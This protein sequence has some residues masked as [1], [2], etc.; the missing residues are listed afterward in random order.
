MSRSGVRRRGGRAAAGVLAVM[1]TVAL[2]ACGG[3]GGDPTEGADQQRN[4]D[5]EKISLTISANA[6]SGGKNAVEADWIEN[7]VIPTFIEQ[8]KEKGVEVDV[9]FEPSGVD[10]EDYKTRLALDL[11][12]GDGADIVNIDGIW[13]GE[14]AET[15]DTWRHWTTSWARPR[16]WDGWEQI[17]EAV[18]ANAM[19]RRR[20]L[21]GV[22]AGTDG[23]VIFFNKDLFAAGRSARGLATDQLGRDPRR[24]QANSRSSRA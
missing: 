13:V 6:I 14:F 1:V 9:T 3:G 2:A 5:A 21:Y 20:E 22:P 23:R 16:A 19:L 7:Y 11:R 18:Q 17:P 4:A 12:S 15:R 8:Q 24:G 10:D